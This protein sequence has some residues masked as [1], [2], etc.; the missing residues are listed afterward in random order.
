MEENQPN[1]DALDS[2]TPAHD[3]GA[4]RDHDDILDTS[5]VDGSTTPGLDDPGSPNEPDL[6]DT[7]VT[8]EPEGQHVDD[9]PLPAPTPD[10]PVYTAPTFAQHL[11]D[12]EN[13]CA[14][15]GGELGNAVRA[16]VVKAREE[17]QHLL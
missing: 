7:G 9:A 1:Y 12:L 14:V 17:L 8:T 16:L 15:Y 11:A 6:D 3:D 2:G 13:A 4:I 10:A 5:G